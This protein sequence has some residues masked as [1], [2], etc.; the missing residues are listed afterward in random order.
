MIKV[1]CSCGKSLKARPE[2]AG[3]R[4]QCPACGTALQI[5]DSPTKSP[6]ETDQI[7]QRR[8]VHAP[9]TGKKSS[10]ERPTAATAPGRK[11]KKRTVDSRRRTATAGTAESANTAWGEAAVDDEFAMVPD[12][13]ASGADGDPYTDLQ[14]YTPASLP[15]RR[16]KKSDKGRSSTRRNP[17]AES[18]SDDEE[19]GISPKMLYSMIGAAVLMVLMLVAVAANSMINARQAETALLAV[20]TE[21]RNFKHEHGR[22]STDYPQGWL[23]ESGGGTG[24][25]PNW[26]SYEQTQQDVKVTIRGSVSGTAVSDIAQSGG[27]PIGPGVDLAD[28]DDPLVAVH[29]F[30][31]DK[32]SAEYDEYSESPPE[33]ID[34]GFGEGRISSFNGTAMFS[35]ICGLRA[36]L[37]SNQYQYTII[38]RCPADR[39]EEY[40]PIFRRLIASVGP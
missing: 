15:A 39:L 36:T 38:C 14:D 10:A 30:Q 29:M 31:K 9:A 7:P 1:R 27:A 4:L 23:V 13:Y 34:S 3:R 20:P 6:N 32:I 16:K 21:F 8:N 19:D 33:K 35:N 22:L 17:A 18:D 40:D 11:K 5:P 28:E 26:I 2:H 24:G 37:V 12:P 25:V